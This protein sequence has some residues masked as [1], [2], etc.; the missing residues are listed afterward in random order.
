MSRHDVALGSPARTALAAGAPVPSSWGPLCTV[1]GLV[2]VAGTV[3]L[4]LVTPVVAAEQL[5]Y[6]LGPSAFRVSEVVWTLTHVL[7]FLGT[8]GLVRSGAAG[9]GRGA[10]VAGRVLLAG[11]A[12]LVPAELGFAFFAGSALDE[13]PVV[14]VSSVIGLAATLAGIG[15][16]AVGVAVLR[17]GTWTGWRRAVP[18]VSGLAVL[19]VL[20]PLQAVAP[21]AFLVGIGVWNLTLALL[22]VALARESSA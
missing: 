16:T 14:V 17:R 9:T 7:T 12:L 4:S 8:L 15:L 3:W 19:G 1:G 20:L 5:S 2:A 13:P 6:P 22:G 21:E 18:L 10:L 11:M